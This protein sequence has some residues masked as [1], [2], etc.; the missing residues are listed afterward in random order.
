MYGTDACESVYGAVKAS[1]PYPLV[2]IHGR[3]SERSRSRMQRGGKSAREHAFRSARQDFNN[4]FRDPDT[5]WCQSSLVE[6]S[7]DR[8]INEEFPE[9]S[10]PMLEGSCWKTVCSRQCKHEEAVHMKEAKAINWCIRR[11]SK[12]LR[13]HTSRRLI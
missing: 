12:D 6:F 10:R 5:V 9:I 3:V 1:Y 13:A 4:V 2:S 8:K 7:D 11:C